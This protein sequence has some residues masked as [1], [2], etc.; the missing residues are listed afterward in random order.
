MDLKAH[1]KIEWC[2]KKICVCDIEKIKKTKEESGGERGM[3]GAAVL[4]REVTAG[5]E[6]ETQTLREVSSKLISP[7]CRR[8]Q[9]NK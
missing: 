4:G 6:S 8:P 9:I 1:G 7:L 2:I 3:R 5:E